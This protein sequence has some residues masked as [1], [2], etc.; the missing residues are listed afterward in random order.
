MPD[1]SVIIPTRNR[2]E[3]LSSLSLP[4]ARGQ[5]DLD[6]EVLVVDDGSTDGT[7]NRLRAIGDPRLVVLRSNTSTGVAGAR[8]RGIAAARGEWLAF[9]DDDDLWSP[10]KLRSQLDVAVAT[11]ADFV[12]A[13]TVVVDARGRAI[14]SQPAPEPATLHDQLLTW[15]IIPAGGS[16]VLARTALVRELG[17]LDE[18]LVH[19]DD[20]DMWIM[21]AAAGRAGSVKEVLV[22]YVVHAANRHS[23]QHDS[24]SDFALLMSKHPLNRP[25]AAIAHARWRATGHRSAGRRFQAAKEYM[26][27]A[28]RYRNAGLFV[29]GVIVLLGERPMR[30]LGSTR[31]RRVTVPR[32][33]ERRLA[34]WVVSP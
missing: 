20:W 28:I 16:N 34:A 33:L 22:A 8:N 15:N 25:A 4:S 17:G 27:A 6:L 9:L 10:R 13:S 30:L 11:K 2:W 31:R 12:Y 18:R 3:L 1:V 24:A 7:E 29:R 5:E 14:E 19:L 23:A 32:W 21:L 26:R